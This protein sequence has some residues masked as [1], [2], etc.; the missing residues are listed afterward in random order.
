MT[1]PAG[2][3]G[4]GSRYSPAGRMNLAGYK[5]QRYISPSTLGCRCSG[6]GGWCRRPM[7]E[8][9]PDRSPGHAFVPICNYASPGRLL[10]QEN[11]PP[12]THADLIRHSDGLPQLDNS[13]RDNTFRTGSAI[14]LLLDCMASST[15]Y[16]PPTQSVGLTSTGLRSSYR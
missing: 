9:I 7:P 1:G 12:E 2:D 15:D 16:G 8:S 10:S 11:T 5:P 3:G 6:D 13:R 4:V 14:I